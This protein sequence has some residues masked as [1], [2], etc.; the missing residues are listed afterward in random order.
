MA[1]SR[2][3][4]ASVRDAAL[5]GTRTH[6]YETASGE[7][8]VWTDGNLVLTCVADGPPGTAATVVAQVSG[9]TGGRD[10]L[11]EIADFVLGPFGWE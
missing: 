5:D 8:V 2:S 4:S 1:C 9:L 6:A 11:D 7:V 10:T 3:P